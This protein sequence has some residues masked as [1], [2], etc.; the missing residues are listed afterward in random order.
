[1]HRAFSALRPRLSVPGR[2]AFDAMEGKLNGLSPAD[3]ATLKEWLREEDDATDQIPSPPSPPKPSNALTNTRGADQEPKP[4]V[5][6]WLKGKLKPDDLE[7][8]RWLYENYKPAEDIPAPFP[9][10]PTPGSEPLP[11]RNAA[12]DSAAGSGSFFAR[13]PMVARLIGNILPSET[14]AQDAR[15]P[16]P[17]ARVR[18]L[19]GGHEGTEFAKRLTARIREV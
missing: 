16:T 12:M 5:W 3:L 6:E 10:R 14:L 11:L 17:A 4:D 7:R 19:V 9:G 15:R 18:V 13:F 8:A 2:M 1:M